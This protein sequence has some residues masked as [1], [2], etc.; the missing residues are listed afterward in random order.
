[1]TQQ[2]NF[3]PAGSTT[4]VEDYAVSL[5]GVSALELAIQPDITH[6]RIAT[7]RC[8]VVLVSLAKL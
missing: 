6:D 7:W 4:E 8:G 1:V 5:Q 3:S 2:W